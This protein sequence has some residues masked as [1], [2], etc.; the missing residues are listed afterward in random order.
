MPTLNDV[1]QAVAGSKFF[2]VVDLRQGFF[3]VPLAKESRPYTAFG[4]TGTRLYQH[5]CTPTGCSISIGLMQQAVTKI[6]QECY[7]RLCSLL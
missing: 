4:T 3:Q 6:V 1:R 5:R 2:T 7:H